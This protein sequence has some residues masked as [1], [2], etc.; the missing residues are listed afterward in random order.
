M[1]GGTCDELGVLDTPFSARLLPLS[2]RIFAI[3]GDI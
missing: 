1:D 2:S 3:P